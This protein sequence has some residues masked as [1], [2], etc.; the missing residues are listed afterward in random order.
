M[1]GD[2]PASYL[3]WYKV[4]TEIK[5]YY[6]LALSYRIMVIEHQRADGLTI[7]SSAALFAPLG[8]KGY[9]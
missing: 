6:Y 8:M 2:M 7:T 4:T 9:I 3:K 5:L 1:V